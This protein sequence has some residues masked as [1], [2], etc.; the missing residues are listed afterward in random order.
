MNLLSLWFMFRTAL[1][2]AQHMNLTRQ[3]RIA[4]VITPT[5][6]PVMLPVST[7]ANRP[8]PRFCDA[9]CFGWHGQRPNEIQ[10]ATRSIAIHIATIVPTIVRFH[11]IT[12]TTLPLN[13]IGSGVMPYAAQRAWIFGRPVARVL[14]IG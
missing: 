5:C 9:F 1:Y 7:P 4:V 12:S 2:S 11:N 8:R 3:D 14:L 10:N 6:R 13:F